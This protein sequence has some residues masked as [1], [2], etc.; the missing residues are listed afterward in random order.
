MRKGLADI[1]RRVEICR[2]ANERYLQA[3]AGVGLPQPVA[4][5]FDPVN[6]RIV[7]D[8]RPYRALQPMNREE[9]AVFRV[10]LRGEF[11]LQG[12][13]NKDVRRAMDPTAE[14]DA[15]SRRQASGRITRLLRLLRAH[16]MIRKVPTTRYYRVTPKGKQVMTTALKLRDA[17]LVAL[18]A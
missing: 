5:T 16:A 14:R 15:D 13:R 9:A 18:A 10:L 2:A 4:K 1:A 6:Q 3:L 7:R 17:D 11:L 8:G 12:F